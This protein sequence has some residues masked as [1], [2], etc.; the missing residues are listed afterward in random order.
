MKNKI[1]HNLFDTDDDDDLREATQG[2]AHVSVEGGGATLRV[3]P[4]LIRDPRHGCTKMSS[5]REDI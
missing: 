1:E 5:L 3:V 2:L 4:Y